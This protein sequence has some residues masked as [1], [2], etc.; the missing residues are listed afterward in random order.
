LELGIRQS[1]GS[2]EEKR[3]KRDGGILFPA[4]HISGDSF[5]LT[6]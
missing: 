4:V 5:L 2:K 3:E 1:E 6:D